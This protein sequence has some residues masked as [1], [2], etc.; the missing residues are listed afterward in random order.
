MSDGRF[1]TLPQERYLE[2]YVEGAVLAEALG[3]IKVGRAPLTPGE[4]G[5]MVRSMQAL[6]I[7]KGTHENLAA[8][9]VRIIMAQSGSTT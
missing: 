2:D 4:A 6:T 1:G 8:V 3:D 7:L 9:D 5:R